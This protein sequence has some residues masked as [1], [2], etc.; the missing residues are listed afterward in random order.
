LK[1]EE[2]ACILLVDLEEDYIYDHFLYRFYKKELK[3]AQDLVKARMQE[4]CDH[5]SRVQTMPIFFTHE[6]KPYPGVNSVNVTPLPYWLMDQAATA[7]ELP[8]QLIAALD[9][10]SKI[11]V[12]GLWRERCVLHVVARLNLHKLPAVLLDDPRFTLEASLTGSDDNI[13]ENANRLYN[14]SLKEVS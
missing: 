10:F 14:A 2:N 11:Y 8:S 13:H 9:G 3:T 4:V 1:Y 5:L 7:K 6:N 12:C